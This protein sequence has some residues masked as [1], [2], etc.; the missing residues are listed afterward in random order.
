MSHKQTKNKK[1]KKDKGRWKHHYLGKNLNEITDQL[2]VWS[3]K[4]DVPKKSRTAVKYTYSL[5]YIEY[6]TIYIVNRYHYTWYPDNQILCLQKPPCWIC[7]NNVIN[8]KW[9]QLNSGFHGYLL[10]MGPETVA[11]MHHHMYNILAY[12]Y[13]F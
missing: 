8:I 4:K 6:N 10:K 13:Y 5:I 2:P 9:D 12:W 1:N 11:L 7:R 3:P